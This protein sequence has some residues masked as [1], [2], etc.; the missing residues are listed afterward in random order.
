M[1]TSTVVIICLIVILLCALLFIKTNNNKS[2]KEATTGQLPDTHTIEYDE[3]LNTLNDDDGADAFDHELDHPDSR[4][5]VSNDYYNMTGDDDLHILTN[6]ETYQQTTE[7]SC[8]CACALM[9][10]NH[11]GVHDYNEMDIARIAESDQSKGTSV[12]GLVK[13]FDSLGWK[14]EYNADSKKPYFGTIEECERFLIKHLDKGTPVMVDWVDWA[15]HWQIIIGLDECGTESPYDDV[16]IMADPYD[17][18]DHNQDG[19]Y[20]FPF[21][22][23]FPM[24]REGPCAE[25]QEPYLQPFVVATPQ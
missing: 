18:T 4:Y 25:K 2:E 24:W 3:K 22:R 12:E 19:Y 14:T 13:F 1:R 5:F 11:Y 16:L 6:F 23:F 21:G 7:Y 20:V 17:V 10:L 15:G 9:V 8:G